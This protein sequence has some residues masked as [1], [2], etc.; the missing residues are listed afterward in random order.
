MNCR[1]TEG[2]VEAQIAIVR[3]ADPS[4]SNPRGLCQGLRHANELV[5]VTLFLPTAP[6]C[7]VLLMSFAEDHLR[8]LDRLHC[9][10]KL[11]C[12]LECIGVLGLKVDFSNILR[13]EGVMRG[14]A[15]TTSSPTRSELAGAG[16]SRPPRITMILWVAVTSRLSVSTRILNMS[17][18][19]G[20]TRIEKIR[21]GCPRMPCMYVCVCM[22]VCASVCSLTAVAIGF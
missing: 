5:H 14:R 1:C 8:G 4:T 17:C 21:S 3:S 19:E 7:P 2:I 22:C 18:S 6:A 20:C 10:V 16:T 12:D 11:E 9:F 15:N 13:R